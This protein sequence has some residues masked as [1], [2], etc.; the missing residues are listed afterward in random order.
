MLNEGD[1]MSRKGP[2]WF[3][4]KLS[5]KQA[6][7]VFILS[8]AGVFLLSM[9]IVPFLFSFV[10]SL[11]QSIMYGEIGF[12]IE[13]TL[14]YMGPYFAVLIVFLIISIYSLSKS[15]KI[16][17]FYSDVIEPQGTESK[18]LLF[19]PNCGNKRTAIEKFCRICGEAL[20]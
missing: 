19:C 5:Q 15:R 1:R 17:Q 9:I 16:A 2:T 20:K 8:F 11:R 7:Q 4:I 18:S 3:G 10:S 13:Y 6:T 12:W 14:L